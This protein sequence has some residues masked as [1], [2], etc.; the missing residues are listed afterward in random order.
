MAGVA[1]FDARLVPSADRGAGERAPGISS[2]TDTAEGFRSP[3]LAPPSSDKA[4]Q[5]EPAI[6]SPVPDGC[7][8]FE[9]IRDAS[10]GSV[11]LDRTPQE[12]AGDVGRAIYYGDP[13]RNMDGV[14][15]LKEVYR[16]TLDQ[17]KGD[18]GEF[19]SHPL[20]SVWNSVKGIPQLAYDTST[21]ALLFDPEARARDRQRIDAIPGYWHG[22]RQAAQAD[23]PYAFGQRTAPASEAVA[24]IGVGGLAADAG[25]AGLGLYRDFAAARDA[26]IEFTNVKDFLAHANDPATNT[27]YK[28]N[29]YTYHTDDLTRTRLIEGVHANNPAGR[30]DLGLQRRIGYSG[31]DTDVGLHLVPD[32]AGAPTS[33]L[34]VVPGNGRALADGLSNLNQG[35]Y[36]QW[37]R[38][39]RA[40]SGD[41][42]NTVHFQVEPQYDPGNLSRRP[43][44]IVTRHRVN[45]GKFEEATFVNKH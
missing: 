7:G 5:N 6:P 29:G 11:M 15:G 3:G 24:M 25:R 38:R 36:A 17:L 45:G 4:R 23:D 16:G 43:D 35:A 33:L 32:S 40:L 14:L 30:N 8:Y 10:R 9:R 13:H 31:Y 2:V 28:F 19:A 26:P 27:A 1:E 39:L 18:L 20:T 34:S 41:P 12:W 42:A 22:L 44:R 21:P 37:E